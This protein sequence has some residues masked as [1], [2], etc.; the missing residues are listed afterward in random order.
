M[1]FVI[2]AIIALIAIIVL[3]YVFDYSRKELKHI[4][5]NEELDELAKAYPSNMKMCREYLKKVKNEKVQIEED[6]GTEASLY[7]AV[8]DKISIANI[9]KSYTRIQTIAHECLHS[10]QSR[11]LL[12]FNFWFSNIYLIY[13]IM[14]C[15]LMIFKLLPYKIMFLA[16]FLILSMIYYMVRIFLENDAM[17]KARYLAKEYMEE[18]EISS[19][20]EIAK[21]VEGFDQINAVGIKCIN[22]HFFMQIMIKVFI[23]AMLGV[24]F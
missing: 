9:Q 5:E 3:G 12:L 22:Y 21:L 2:I 16:I 7:I 14:I 8:T 4:G 10:V 18:K 6:E 23:I 11:K 13:F 1:E 15:V 24:I 17:I 20:K 19:T